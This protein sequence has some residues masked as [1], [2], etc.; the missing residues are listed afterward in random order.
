MKG[1]LLNWRS[2]RSKPVA[3]LGDGVSGR[4]VRHLLETL[5]WEGRV[6]DEKGELFDEYAAK[7]SS[8]IVISPGFRKDHPWVRLALDYK[9]ILLTELDFAF[10]FLSS[11]IVSIT[12]TN[13]KTTLTSLLAHIWD[14]MHKPFVSAGNIG[15]SLSEAVASGI[16]PRATVFLETSSFQAERLSHLKPRSVLWTNFSDD[17]LDHHS[18]MEDYFLAKANLLN[19]CSGCSWVGESVAQGFKELRLKM[20]EACKVISR[21][22]G[23]G[24]PLPEN[25]FLSTYPQRENLAL[26]HAFCQSES[27]GERIF[28]SLIKDYRGYD[29]RLKKIAELEGVSFWNDSKATNFAATLSACDSMEG[30]IFWIGGGRSKGGNLTSFVESIVKKIRKAFLFGEVGHRMKG[31]FDERSFPN[32]I[33]QSVEEA[34]GKAYGSEVAPSTILFSPGFASFDTHCNYAERGKNFMEVV[35]DLK[36]KLHGTTQECFT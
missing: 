29:H 26:A 27:I 28:F 1:P 15:L 10:C 6:F 25:H 33:C 30:D 5:K 31:L 7:S 21:F 4:G 3:I 12:G 2:M 20:P 16:D 17:H 22:E 14:K 8:V 18:S 34:V 36:N 9:K 35:F 32:E 23:K 11:P 19:Q 24:L 13:G